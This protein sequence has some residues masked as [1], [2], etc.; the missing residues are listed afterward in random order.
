MNAIRVFIAASVLAVPVLA[1]PNFSG[2]WEL[3]TSKSKNIG[4]MAQLKLTATVKQTRDELVVT[5][6]SNFNGQEQTNEL[7]FDLSGKSVPNKNPMEGTAETVS[8]WDGNHLVTTWTSEG[9]VAGTKSVRIETRS[10]S[11]DDR[12]LTVESR[13]G[14]APAMVMVYERK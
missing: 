8:K 11:D 3:N 14:Q 2:K 9:S 12:M 5:N 4:M 1:Q 7:R 6:V 13:R 10:L